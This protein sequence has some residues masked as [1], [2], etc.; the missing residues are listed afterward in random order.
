MTKIFDIEGNKEKCQK[1][2]PNSIVETMLNLVGYSSDL[3]G[4]KVL[5][6]SFGSGNILKVIVRRYIIDSIKHGISPKIISERIS[7]DIV[8]IEYDKILFQTCKK[9]LNAIANEYGLTNIRWNIHNADALK[10]DYK[11]KF[12]YII[13]NPPY[14]SY[15]RI[16]KDSRLKINKEFSTCKTGKFDYC[17]AFIELGINLL[18]SNGRMIQLVPSNIFKNYYAQDL[19]DLLQTNVSIIYEYP[20]QNLFESALTSSSMFVYDKNTTS[21]RVEY[22][23][24]TLNEECSI[25]RHNLNGKWIFENIRHKNNGELKFGD[26]FKASVTIATLCNEA[27]LVNEKQIQDLNLEKEII[28]T[29]ISPRSIRYNREQYIIFPYTYSDGKISKID[30]KVFSSKY[31]SVYEHLRSFKEVL[32]KRDS[33]KNAKWF[34]Y[35]RS[36]A[37]SHVK[38]EKLLLS[39]IITDSVEVHRLTED[40][41]PYSGIYITLINDQYSLDDAQKILTSIDF[42]NYIRKVGVPVN[43]SSI[44]ISSRDINEYRFTWR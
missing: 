21:N 17:Y 13:G 30:E 8:G 18:K 16:D 31:P 42:L 3:L 32:E 24:I 44:R 43:G 11:I 26:Y 34:E 4:K 7:E 5:E 12:D 40:A 10:W 38:K 29:A 9:E 39:T 2:T 25:P 35:G 33:D 19:R 22:K 41:I 37:L 20:R 27:F 1:F 28:K 23:N 6:N 14:I 15:P 36:Q